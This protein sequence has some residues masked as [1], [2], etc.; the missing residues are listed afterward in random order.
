MQNPD[1]C[2][3]IDDYA[4]NIEAANAFGI[5]GFLFEGYE[6]SYPIIM[7]YLNNK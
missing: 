4:A 2:M 5:H 6:N 7:E 3:F 1:E